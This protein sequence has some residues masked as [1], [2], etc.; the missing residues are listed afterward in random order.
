MNSNYCY[1]YKANLGLI[2]NLTGPDPLLIF[3]CV[4]AV[5]FLIWLLFRKR[6]VGF[7]ELAKQQGRKVSNIKFVP[8]FF[9]SQRYSGKGFIEVTQDSI[10]VFGRRKWPFGKKVI[11]FIAVTMVLAVVGHVLGLLGAFF[12]SSFM[13]R[14]RVEDGYSY[15]RIQS[16]TRETPVRYI[17]KLNRTDKEKECKIVF[18]SK[19]FN[20]A[21]E[22]VLAQIVNANNPYK[23]ESDA[24]MEK[25]DRTLNTVQ[26]NDKTCPIPVKSNQLLAISEIEKRVSKGDINL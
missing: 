14:S 13:F 3:L 16:I 22:V 25:K 19:E 24:S 11:G 6:D 15:E 4:L 7:T 23:V 26:I 21:Y 17:L 2:T 12:L 10:I 5:P 18:E 1:P 8:S 20:Q 9:H